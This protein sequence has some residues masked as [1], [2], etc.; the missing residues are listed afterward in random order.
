MSDNNNLMLLA[1]AGG[2]AWWYFRGKDALNPMSDKNAAYGTANAALG[3]DNK[4]ASIGTE[5]YR[6]IEQAKK[7][8]GLNYDKTTDDDWLKQP[9]PGG[10]LNRPADIS[11]SALAPAGGLQ[12]RQR[13]GVWYALDK[14]SWRPTNSLERVQKVGDKY[15]AIP[16][17][18]KPNV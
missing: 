6:K 7:R 14:G 18:M 8:L 1:I 12:A 13:G 10:F 5:A 15:F 16:W 3:L 2:V 9:G 17:Y 4:T 11:P